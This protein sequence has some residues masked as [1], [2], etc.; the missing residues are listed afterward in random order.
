MSYIGNIPTTVAF[1]VDTFSGDGSDT[2]FTLSQAPATTSSILVAVSG[3]VQDP[4]TYSVSGTTLTFSGAPPSGSSNISVRFLGIPASGVA[5]TAYRTLTTFT[6]TSGQT[7][8]SVPSYTVGYID[9]YRN[10]VKLGTAD[11][12]AT[13]GTTVVLASGATA[14]DLVETVS[15]FVSSVLNAI[16]AVA[17]A[18]T[19]SYINDGAVTKAKMA[20]S[21]AWA[22][23]GTVLQ[24]VNGSLSTAFSTTSTSFVDTGLTA[25]ITPTSTSSKILAIVN[26]NGVHSSDTSYNVYFT[27]IRNSTNLTNV[28]LSNGWGIRSGQSIGRWGSDSISYLDSPSTT[29][30]TTYKIQLA[31]EGSGRTA[32]VSDVNSF[33]AL[34]TITLMEIAG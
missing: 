32:Y 4:S 14:G 34:S 12:T 13:S 22:P 23:A 25:S 15:F 17:N 20:A 16:P 24:V 8:F 3:V 7:T 2:T 6:A 11:F 21:G 31:S 1:L 30:A 9:V 28:S 19:T 5:T 33:N 27:L 18:V 10:G 29:S 26:L